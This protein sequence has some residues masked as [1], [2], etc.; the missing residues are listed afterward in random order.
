VVPFVDAVL[1]KC[2]HGVWPWSQLYDVPVN[3][4]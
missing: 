4:H 2:V 1:A 3:H